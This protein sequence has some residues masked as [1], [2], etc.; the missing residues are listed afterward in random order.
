MCACL[1]EC[2][3]QRAAVIES[4]HER[5]RVTAGKNGKLKYME[6]YWN[7]A[8][9]KVMHGEKTWNGTEHT[10]STLGKTPNSHVYREVNEGRGR[11]EGLTHALTCSLARHSKRKVKTG[12]EEIPPAMKG[13]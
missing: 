7:R 11:E 9:R 4:L 6:K 2:M 8:E 1:Y 12:E 3:K 5:T 10:N 13:K